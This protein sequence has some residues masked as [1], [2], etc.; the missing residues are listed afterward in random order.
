MGEGERKRVG[1]GEREGEELHP[2]GYD[3]EIVLGVQE[4]RLLSLKSHEFVSVAAMWKIKLS[5]F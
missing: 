2:E 1:E 4:F 3:R 5:T